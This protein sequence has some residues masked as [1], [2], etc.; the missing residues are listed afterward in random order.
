MDS[1]KRTLLRG[2]KK[3]TGRSRDSGCPGDEGKKLMITA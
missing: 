3:I 2:W 1:I